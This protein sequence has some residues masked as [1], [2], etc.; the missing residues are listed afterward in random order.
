MLLLLLCLPLCHNITS[1]L[2]YAYLLVATW[3]DK[4]FRRRVLFLLCFSNIPFVPGHMPYRPYT[5]NGCNEINHVGVCAAYTVYLFSPLFSVN[6]CSFVL[7][8]HWIKCEYQFVCVPFQV[9]YSVKVFCCCLPLWL[10]LPVSLLLR[11][12]HFIIDFHS[13]AQLI[14][15]TTTEASSVNFMYAWVLFTLVNID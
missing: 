11:A 1:V 7:N 4:H 3:I 15:A 9:S 12:Y 6:N 2:S 10:P 5:V 13:T 14:A 8:F